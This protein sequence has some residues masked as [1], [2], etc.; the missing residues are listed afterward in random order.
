MLDA[1]RGLAAVGV[2]LHHEAPLYHSP[3]LFPRAYLAV[4][5]FFMLSGFVLTLAFEPKLRAGMGAGDF[6][7]AGWRGYGRSWRWAC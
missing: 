2:V 4:D 7:P 3:G 6:C 5:F 1:L